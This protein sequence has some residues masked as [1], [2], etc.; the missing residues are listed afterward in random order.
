[1]PTERA[2]TCPGTIRRG[3]LRPPRG[4][5]VVFARARRLLSSTTMSRDAI[6]IAGATGFVGQAVAQ[7]LAGRTTPP[8]EIVGLTRGSRGE[9]RVGSAGQLRLVLAQGRR[10]RA[11]GR[12]VRRL[13]RALDAAVR[14]A[15][16]GPVR[17]PRSDLRRQLRARGE[18]GRGRADRLPR[19]ADPGGRAAVRA[20]REPARGRGRARLARRAGH[21]PAR[22]HG[23]R[24]R[25]LVVRDPH[26]P[27]PAAARDGA[28]E[29]ERAAVPDRSISRPWPR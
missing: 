16:A 7:R 13:P 5:Q 22:R 26:P 10:A 15:R 2:A 20:P 23:D 12:A 21:D 6:V 25:R 17:R 9:R 1:M 4:I 29:V 11:P 19:R 28:A 14:A 3:N 8:L 18:G 27:G 24:A